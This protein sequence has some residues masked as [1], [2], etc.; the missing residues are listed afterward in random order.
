MGKNFGIKE[1]IY[2]KWILCF[3]L[4]SIIKEN[5][6]LLGKTFLWGRRQEDVP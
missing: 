3:Q 4:L 1:E 6:A 5:C 2:R